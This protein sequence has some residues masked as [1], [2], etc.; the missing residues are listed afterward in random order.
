[1]ELSNEFRMGVSVPEAWRD[2]DA[3]SPSPWI[4]LWW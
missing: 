2:K 3:R 1:M 4:R